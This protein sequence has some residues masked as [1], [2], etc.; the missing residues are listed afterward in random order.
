MYLIP[1]KNLFQGQGNFYNGIA[2]WTAPETV[3]ATGKAAVAAAARA[4]D[5]QA[6]LSRQVSLRYLPL[7]PLVPVMGK[8]QEWM[9]KGKRGENQTEEPGNANSVLLEGNNASDAI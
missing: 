5:G 3:T 7:A 8:I 4:R 9:M 1:L 6:L 2:S